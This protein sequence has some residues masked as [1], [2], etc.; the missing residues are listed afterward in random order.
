MDPAKV[1]KKKV[2]LY[3]LVL[4]PLDKQTPEAQLLAMGQD[5]LEFIEGHSAV[6][7]RSSVKSMDRY[8]LAHQTDG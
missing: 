6:E 4:G 5:R 7:G 3:R 8:I 1:G 2:C